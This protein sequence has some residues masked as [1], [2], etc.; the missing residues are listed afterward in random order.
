MVDWAGGVLLLLLGVSGAFAGS[1]DL[2]ELTDVQYSIQILD[3]P[4]S[5]EDQLLDES[6]TSTMMVNREGQRYRCSVPRV[7]EKPA[8]EEQ[9]MHGRAATSLQGEAAPP[10]VQN[11]LRSLEDAPCIFKT[12]DWWTYEICYNRSEITGERRPDHP[13]RMIKQ[14]HVENDRPVGAVMVLGVHR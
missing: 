12:K 6:A 5:D 8:E 4:V 13:C 1:Q 9:V 14:Y 10:D 3:T 2:Q 11:L 7:E